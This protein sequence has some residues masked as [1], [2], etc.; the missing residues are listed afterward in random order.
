[1][2]ELKL[3]DVD[4]DGAIRESAEEAR[5]EVIR[6]GGEGD[7]R[8]DFF[9]KAGIAGGAVVGGGALMGALVP[10]AAS[11]GNGHGNPRN[12]LSGGRPP[13]G[14]GKGDI[15]I[16]NYALTLEYLEAE[17]YKEAQANNHGGLLGS[18]F[19]DDQASV[20]LDAVVRDEKAHVKGLKAALGRKA[21]KKPKFDFG[22][23]T[24]ETQPFLET[25]YALE[26]HRRRRLLRPGVQHQEARIPR[27]RPV[28]RHDR[29][30]ARRRHR[31]AAQEQ[32]RRH[33]PR[34]S[35]RQ[36]PDGPQ[37]PEGGRGD[38]LHPGLSPAARRRGR[39]LRSRRPAS[40]PR[41]VS[42]FPT[43]RGTVR[44]VSQENVEIVRRGYERWLATGGELF[45]G[46]AH[47]DFVWDMSTFRDWPERQ[48]YPGAEGARQFMAEWGDA[49]EDWELEVEDYLDAGERVV[50][51]VRQH[52]RSKAS[53]VSVDMHFAQVWTIRDGQQVRMQMYASTKEALEATG[54]SE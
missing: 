21:A 31:V 28:D 16:L 12:G 46:N 20:F 5:D 6:E 26:K 8:L 50:V 24:S 48:T 34:R 22:N 18:G 44:S 53:G 35:V 23:T 4:V 7:T 40:G 33:R 45:L 14:F 15:G 32:R 52:G 17:F 38:R 41:G 39:L 19:L 30:T 1:M 43:S 10:A 27:G 25:A 47:P 54:L 37:G 29:G 3:S 49:W 13:K 51:I 11:A 42:R 9:K 2:S 36:A